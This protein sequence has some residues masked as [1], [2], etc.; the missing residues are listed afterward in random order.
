[1]SDLEFRPRFKIFTGHNPDESLHLISAKLKTG[2][3]ENYESELVKG[4]IV[5]RIHR[6]KKH[7]WSPQMDISIADDPETGR[8]LIRCLLA[9]APVVWTMFMFFYALA[10]FSALVGSTIAMSQWSL[11]KDLWGLW[12]VGISLL[13][14]ITLFFIAQFGKGLAQVEMIALKDF[15]TKID[16]GKDCEITH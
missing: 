12:V 16:W 13:L 9:P 4:H 14:G 6:S 8:T 1:M 5:L 3:P 11:K 15:I 10:G 7:F 2:N